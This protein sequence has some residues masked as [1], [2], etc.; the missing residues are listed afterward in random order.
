V[1]E[2]DTGVTTAVQVPTSNV[3]LQVDLLTEG[4]LAQIL[5]DLRA[6]GLSAEQ[7]ARRLLTQ[8]G[9]VVSTRTIA[10]W[11]KQLGI[12]S[13]AGPGPTPGTPPSGTPAGGE[14][15]AVAS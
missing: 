1:P 15:E 7:I 5:E 3:W 13:P 11:C 14:V 6:A 4:H 10:N 9:A 12:S 2:D 8:H